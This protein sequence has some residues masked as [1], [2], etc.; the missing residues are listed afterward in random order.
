MEKKTYSKCQADPVT[1]RPKPEAGNRIDHNDQR[2]A[3]PRPN[4]PVYVTPR[5]LSFTPVP[6]HPGLMMFDDVWWCLMMFDVVCGLRSP[7]L[8]VKAQKVLTAQL[9][10]KFCCL[11][12]SSEALRC[13]LRVFYCS[14][15]W[16]D[17][18]KTEWKDGWFV[19]SKCVQPFTSLA[20]HPSL[21]MMQWYR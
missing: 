3:I 1:I 17:N 19:F 10:H 21:D 9:D 7:N 11:C 8:F 14:N 16:H 5:C 20:N 13:G 4:L 12:G 18:K 15:H 2:K 6:C